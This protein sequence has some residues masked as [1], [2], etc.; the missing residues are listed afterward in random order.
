VGKT[1]EEVGRQ[2]ATSSL[3]SDNDVKSEAAA[4]DM[5]SYSLQKK[6][7]RHG[8]ICG[9]QHGVS[10]YTVTPFVIA[11]LPVIPCLY[12]CTMV[13]LVNGTG[14]PWVSPA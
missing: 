14:N 10:P 1:P 8:K 2:T 4:S 13:R 3:A 11:L 9:R 12:I 5:T 7:N 6:K